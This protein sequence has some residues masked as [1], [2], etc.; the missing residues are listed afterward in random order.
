MI[1]DMRKV[2]MVAEHART[3]FKLSE[4]LEQE[5]REAKEAARLRHE[6]ERLLRLRDPA[7]KDP[8]KESTY[9]KLVNILW[10]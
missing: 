7:A 8:G 10:R 4:A 5:P 6:A 3:I 1:T 2:K 9:D